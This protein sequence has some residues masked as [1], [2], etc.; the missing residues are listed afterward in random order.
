MVRE[1]L[2]IYKQVG[3][4]TLHVSPDGQTLDER[5]ANL[6]RL[7]DLVKEINAEV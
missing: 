4:N 1:R 2:R 6:A 5:V 7:V 3:V